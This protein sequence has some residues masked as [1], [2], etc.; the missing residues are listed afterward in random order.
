MVLG[1]CPR[2]AAG[3]QAHRPPRRA[4]PGLVPGVQCEGWAPA[5]YLILRQEGVRSRKGLITRWPK[6]SQGGSALHSPNGCKEQIPNPL[7][8]TS[9]SE[10]KWEVRGKNPLK[11]VKYRFSFF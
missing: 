2:R 10:G 11:I 3:T 5:L 9:Q 6:V 4:A 7:W 8:R 1:G